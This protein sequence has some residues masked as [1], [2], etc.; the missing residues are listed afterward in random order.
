MGINNMIAT[1]EQQQ[2]QN[3][4]RYGELKT[5]RNVQLTD[6]A[7]GIADALAI[8]HDISRSE[9]IE[10]LLRGMIQVPNLAQTAN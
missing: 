5:Q 10:Q 3:K 2:Q 1:I 6:T 8:A 4:T 7:I 9:V